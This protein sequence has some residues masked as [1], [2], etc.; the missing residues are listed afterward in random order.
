M[1]LLLCCRNVDSGKIFRHLGRFILSDEPESAAE[2]FFSS[3]LRALAAGSYIPENKK[4]FFV[5][6]QLLFS[7]DG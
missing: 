7:I 4:H 3:F 6:H 1:V 5:A 2:S